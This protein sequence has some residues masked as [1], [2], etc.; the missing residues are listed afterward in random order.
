MSCEYGWLVYLGQKSGRVSTFCFAT[1]PVRKMDLPV[2]GSGRLGGE[3]AAGC[4]QA[5]H[6]PTDSARAPHDDQQTNIVWQDRSGLDY[7]SPLRW[8]EVAAD[9]MNRLSDTYTGCSF[10]T[11]HKG[12]TWHHWCF[13]HPMRKQVS[14]LESIQKKNLSQFRVPWFYV[15]KKDL[16]PALLLALP[17]VNSP[18]LTGVSRLLTLM[19]ASFPLVSHLLPP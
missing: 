7:W 13:L 16:T 3:T 18:F 11:L 10:D 17:L 12:R 6:R 5:R 14:G 2:L 4:N 19:V 1:F 15:K 8:C 9:E